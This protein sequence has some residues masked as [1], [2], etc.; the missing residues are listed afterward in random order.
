VAEKEKEMKARYIIPLIVVGAI[1]VTGIG[2]EISEYFNDKETRIARLECK[3]KGVHER[4]DIIEGEWLDKE[5]RA[6][7]FTARCR[8]CG[9]T[10][11]HYCMYH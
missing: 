5:K 8:H 10:V 7:H 3:D 6:C 2:I 9:Y 11:K 4:M 1:I